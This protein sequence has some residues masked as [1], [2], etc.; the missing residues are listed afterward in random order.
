MCKNNT[1][2]AALAGA[3]SGSECDDGFGHKSRDE[4]ENYSDGE[5]KTCGDHNCFRTLRQ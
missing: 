3:S 1:S 5:H 4:I 2:C